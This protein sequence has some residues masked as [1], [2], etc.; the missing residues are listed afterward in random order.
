[1]LSVITFLSM[2]ING[3]MVKRFNWNIP[4]P[5]KKPE[6]CVLFPLLPPFKICNVN[7]K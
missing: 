6:K 4:L 1:M 7:C 5:H 3:V 2:F